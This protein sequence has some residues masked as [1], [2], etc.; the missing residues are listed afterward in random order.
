MEGEGK[1]GCEVRKSMCE[2]DE[3]TGWLEREKETLSAVRA[4]W[5]L[6][7]TS[8][9]DT[10]QSFDSPKIV[11]P[12]AIEKFSVFALLRSEPNLSFSNGA[13]GSPLL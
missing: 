5:L 12:Y 13:G 10:P 1:G 2:R 3:E 9:L 8:S 7:L 11:L 4:G 6:V